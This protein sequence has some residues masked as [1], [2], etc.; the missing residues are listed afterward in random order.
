[1]FWRTLNQLTFRHYSRKADVDAS[2]LKSY[3]PISNLS[4]LS[5]LPERVVARQLNN[6]LQQS[7]LIPRLKSAYR[8]LHSTEATLLKVLSDIFRA[9]DRGAIAA[10][11]LLDLPAAFDTV[12]D[13]T[14]FI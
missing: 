13:A 7:G 12:D 11:A 10:L 14:L 6:H 1:M 5:K 3:R 8:H 4:I 9:V 2:D